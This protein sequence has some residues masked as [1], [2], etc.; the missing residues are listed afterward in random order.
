MGSR[1]DCLSDFELTSGS[2]GNLSGAKSTGKLGGTYTSNRGSISVQDILNR[3]PDSGLKDNRD[4]F[5]YY[6]IMKKIEDCVLSADFEK[7][8]RNR[9]LFLGIQPNQDNQWVSSLNL[10][11]L[12]ELLDK[13]GLAHFNLGIGMISNELVIALDDSCFHRWRHFG[14]SKR[15]DFEVVRDENPMLL[16]DYYETSDTSALSLFSF[17][18]QED[19]CDIHSYEALNLTSLGL[20]SIVDDI[21]KGA[22]IKCDMY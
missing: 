11:A 19:I 21:L 18:M 13:E 2:N 9:L 7:Y 4:L 10:N 1:A 17:D 14:V 20:E 16:R 3:N 8:F 5:A 12:S 22:G 15:P 6:D